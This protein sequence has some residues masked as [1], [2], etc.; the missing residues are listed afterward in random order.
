MV[1]AELIQIT[2]TI[3]GK[4]MARSRCKAIVQSGLQIHDLTPQIA[5]QAGLFKCQYSNLP[6]GD[7]VIAAT[8]LANHARVL[9]DDPHFDDVAGIK[10]VWI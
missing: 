2:C 8:A 4:D 3:R 7:C 1:I 6:M 9:S 5:E 10:R